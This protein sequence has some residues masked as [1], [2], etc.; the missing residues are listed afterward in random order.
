M[1]DRLLVV[2][3]TPPV[4]C[5]YLQEMEIFNGAGGGAPVGTLVQ[6]YS[7]CGSEFNIMVGSKLV[8]TPAH[9]HIHI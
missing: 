8:S 9:P 1:Y 6:E 7:C 2:A 4:C 5:C 3:G